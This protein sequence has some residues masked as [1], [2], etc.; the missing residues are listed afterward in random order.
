M[1]LLKK[2]LFKVLLRKLWFLLFNS[3][4]ELGHARRDICFQILSHFWCGIFCMND[5][6][7]WMFSNWSSIYESQG[8][9]WKGFIDACFIFIYFEGYTPTNYNSWKGR[10]SE[11]SIYN[12]DNTTMYLS[13]LY[14]CSIILFSNIN[15]YICSD[16]L[17]TNNIKI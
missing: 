3:D 16:Y 15:I 1:D 17:I 5:M 9:K 7:S 12:L 2:I 14:S 13:F 10:R 4:G 11:R 8:S 6:I